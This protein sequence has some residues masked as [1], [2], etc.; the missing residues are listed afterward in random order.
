MSKGVG[1]VRMQPPILSN[2]LHPLGVPH[3]G[4]RKFPASGFQE[5]SEVGDPDDCLEFEGRFESSVK[6]NGA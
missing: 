2:F 1:D 3:P 5:S 6:N 4:G